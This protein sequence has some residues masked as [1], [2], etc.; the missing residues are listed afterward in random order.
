MHDLENLVTFLGHAVP[1][2]GNVSDL[3]DLDQGSARLGDG[4]GL[5]DSSD[6]RCTVITT[7][8]LMES[9]LVGQFLLTY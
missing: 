4:I 9:S 2:G 3:T 7:P 1:Q 6:W 5:M 8:D